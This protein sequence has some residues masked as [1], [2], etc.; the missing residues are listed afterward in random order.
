MIRIERIL[1][2]NPSVYTLEGTNAWVVGR[3]P[4]IV[5]D[6]GPDD[7]PEH[8][9]ELAR[10]AGEVAHV[11]VTH[12]H[13]DHA[14]GAA[15]F[16]ARV[17][18]PLWAAKLAGAEPIRDGA[19]FRGGGVEIAAVLTPGHTPDHVAFWI[20]SERALFTGDAVLGR[21][22]SVID[23]PEGD[24]ARY[25]A[26]LRRMLDLGPRTIYPG[27]GP[28]VADGRAKLEEYL[29][30]RDERERQVLDALASGAASI[31]E[32]VERIYE[33]YP[34]DVF[35]LAARSVLAHLKKLETEGRVERVGRGDAAPWTLSEPRA[36]AR[37]GRPVRSRARYCTSCNL[38]MLQEGAPEVTVGSTLPGT[39]ENPATVEAPATVEL[40]EI[41]GDREPWVPLLLEADEEIPLRAYLDDGDLLE[42]RAGGVTGDDASGGTVG[43]VLLFTEGSTIE[44]KNLAIAEPHRRRGFGRAAIE[45]IVERAAE[46]GAERVIVGTA[47]TGYDSLAFY[48]A[49]GFTDAGRRL[50]F[51]DTYPEPVILDGA[52]AHDMVMFERILGPRGTGPTEPGR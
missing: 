50:G 20:A 3:D 44:I 5:I 13:P 21:G 17:G 8:Q 36:C 23:P 31:D 16:A 4:S 29:G 19:T 24:L 42:I 33:G 1:A 7:L 18:A 10:A 41:A 15:A 39:A 9:D 43:V 12:D 47:D 46:A 25:V 2:P 52:E 45:L 11:L 27:H 34:R 32:I 49:C 26:S 35:P 28:I 14:P 6:P 40:V 22:T 38:I 51:F 48:R 30:H 37:C